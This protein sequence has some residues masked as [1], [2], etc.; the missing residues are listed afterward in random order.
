MFVT[1][2]AAT[3]LAAI[4]TGPVTAAWAAVTMKRSGQLRG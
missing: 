3:L 2:F 1:M 4:R